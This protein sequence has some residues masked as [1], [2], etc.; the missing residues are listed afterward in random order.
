MRS[1]KE[2]PKRIEPKT[3]STGFRTNCSIWHA[4]SLRESIQDFEYSFLRGDAF[5]SSLFITHHIR[6]SCLLDPFSTILSQTPFHSS[7]T[8]SSFLP[9]NE[10]VFSLLVTFSCFLISSGEQKNSQLNAFS[11]ISPELWTLRE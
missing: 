5:S 10:Y 8:C 3:K 6:V 4:N 11:S 1:Y 2:N 7:S 9:V